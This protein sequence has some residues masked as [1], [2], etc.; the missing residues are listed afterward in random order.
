MEFPPPLLPRRFL[1]TQTCVIT[2]EGGVGG[3]RG[4]K[5]DPRGQGMGGRGY[6]KHRLDRHL[7]SVIGSSRWYRRQLSITARGGIVDRLSTIAGSAGGFADFDRPIGGGACA[8][9]SASIRPCPDVSR[10]V[11]ACFEAANEMHR[12]GPQCVPIS[13]VNGPS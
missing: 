8:E 4:D 7:A 13:V 11:R 9:F 3:G 2:L 6:S 10:R 1:V 5:G 12:S